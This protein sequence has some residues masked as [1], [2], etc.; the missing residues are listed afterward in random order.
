VGKVTHHEVEDL[1]EYIS[2]KSVELGLFKDQLAIH[3]NGEH[4]AHRKGECGVHVLHLVRSGLLQHL[5][6]YLDLL[7]EG[8]YIRQAFVGLEDRLVVVELNLA[9]SF[10]GALVEQEHII[11]DREVG[12]HRGIRSRTEE[13]I[14]DELT[15]QL[16]I[17]MN[18][19]F[20][21]GRSAHIGSRHV[22]NGVLLE[23]LGGDH[24]PE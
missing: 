8:R 9:Q 2:I 15:N 20:K 24:V 6:E 3:Y 5:L 23:T 18:R 1:V 17:H 10:G 21:L 12:C 13:V 11:F 14:L 19:A 4:L 22:E 16:H 7:D